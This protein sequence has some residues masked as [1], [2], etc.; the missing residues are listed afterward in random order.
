MNKELLIQKLQEIIALLQEEPL[1]PPPPITAEEWPKA[2]EIINPAKEAQDFLNRSM[3]QVENYNVLDFGAG[4]GYLSSLVGQ[5]AKKTISYDIAQEKTRLEPGDTF[6]IVHSLEEIQQEGPYDLILIKDV[7][8]H[9]EPATSEESQLYIEQLHIK[10]LMFLKS[11]LASSGK[12]Y[13][14]THPWTSRHG[15]HLYHTQNMAFIHLILSD[16]EYLEKSVSSGV[17][18]T[19][20]IFNAEKYYKRCINKS[21]LNLFKTTLIRE[22]LED[23]VVTR[24]LDPIKKNNAG[25]SL[26][27]AELNNLLSISYIDFLL[28]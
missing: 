6:K 26:S 3:M 4:L 21:G 10:Y 7:F 20:Q 9:L 24:L 1:A 2:K 17:K 28:I 15:G 16:K 25:L 11:C 12:I 5:K 22:E 27:D 18:I 13:L 14:R 23:F 19:H 8:D